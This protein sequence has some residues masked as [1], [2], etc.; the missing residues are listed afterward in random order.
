MKPQTFLTYSPITSP[1]PTPQ[2]PTL[3]ASRSLR[4]SA[5]SPQIFSQSPMDKNTSLLLFAAAMLLCAEFP[6]SMATKRCPDCGT[7][8]VPYPLSTETDCGDQSYKIR[9]VSGTL[10]FDA[11]NGSSYTITS[12][13]PE[14]Q[15]LV[16]SPAS[17][18]GNTCVTTD[19]VSEGLH[20]NSSLPFNITSSNTIMYLNCT[21][22][23]LRSPL[24]CSST[25]LCHTYIN[26]T[27]EAAPCENAPICC[28]FRTGGSTTSYMIR[29]RDAGCRAYRSFVNL[30]PS[31]PVSRWP[32][33]G[34][35]MEWA[36]PKEPICRSQADCDEGSNSTCSS[37]PADPRLSRCFCR[38]GLQW[39]P[40]N[41]FCAN[42]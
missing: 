31:L 7:T 2:I 12:I 41:G 32:Q 20:L 1:T 37:D 19:I 23:L 5:C 13:S 34:L 18:A 9:C 29:V 28:S 11:L 33:P 6:F 14:N 16:I 15:R 4:L 22:I 8:P 26:N 40:I 27:A 17:F 3:S 30:D 35:E 36:L 39:D 42:I 25:S 21:D 38:A 24:D 10:L